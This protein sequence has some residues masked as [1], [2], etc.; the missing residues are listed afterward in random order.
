[1]FTNYKIGSRLQSGFALILVLSSIITT[2]SLWNLNK[3]SE[4]SS[5]MMKRPLLKERLS[6]DW[7]RSIDS[8]IMRTT[9]IAKSSDPSLVTFLATD[10]PRKSGDLQ[11]NIGALLETEEEK[12]LFEKIGNQRKLYLTARDK[13]GKLKAEGSADL[14]TEVLEKE[15]VPVANKF[16]QLLQELLKIQRDQIDAINVNI[17]QTAQ[18]SMRA[19]VILEILA[20]LFAIGI[21]CFL[22]RSIVKPLET[23]VF[24]AGQVAKGDLTAHIEI[25][26]RD[27]IGLLMMALKTMNNNLHELVTNIR[28]SVNN[29]AVVSSEIAIGNQD[30]S[31]RTEQ[32]ASSLEETAS[33]TEE[34]TSTIRQTAENAGLAKTTAALASQAATNGGQAVSR[35]I[36]TMKS[37]DESSQKIASII[38]VID[39]IAFQTNILAL[40]AA[41][42]AARAGEQG[43]GFAVVAAEVRNL[44]QRSTSAAKEIKTLIMDSVERTSAG[45][46]LVGVA[47]DKIGEIVQRVESVSEIIAG[48]SLSSQEQATGITQISESINLLDD[49]TQKNAAL[50]EQASAAAS[51]MKDEA[52]ALAR[53]VS[54]F[55]IKDEQKI[56]PKA[57]ALPVR[58]IAR[59]IP[60]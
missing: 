44:A 53:L 22:T 9:A 33:A 19:L 4:E 43:R 24:V 13:I 7:Y 56:A 40:N 30:L 46:N 26:S 38:G 28:S 36:E 35:V 57:A 41:V 15:Y 18:K 31:D 16:R 3:V 58:S 27:E 34:I 25:G 8:G 5:A 48:I 42:E 37:I 23:A 29:I 6:S 14:A 55:L 20:I 60:T 47:G 1:M 12:I 51:A 54:I 45:K 49:V 21:A 50:V 32:Q 59:L 2:I 52:A 11:E 10:G 17:E 39:G